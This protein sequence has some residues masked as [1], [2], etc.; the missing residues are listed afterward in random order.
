MPRKKRGGNLAGQQKIKCLKCKETF[1]RKDNLIRHT[2]ARHKEN[3]LSCDKCGE[4]FSKE[5]N[6]KRHII[7]KHS[8]A[9]HDNNKFTCD[10]CGGNIQDKTI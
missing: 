10:E 9:E 7:S 3:K 6:L 5:D 4:Y 2:I 8:Q 1:S